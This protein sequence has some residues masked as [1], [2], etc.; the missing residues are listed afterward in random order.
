MKINNVILRT[1]ARVVV[2]II[3]TLAVYLFLAGHNNPGGGFI[4]G[5]V[6]STAFVLLFIVFDI[7]TIQKALP[8]DF[9]KVAAL[10][11]LLAVGT[12]F[13]SFLF[14]VSF[15]TQAFDYFD[16]PFF[17]E[18]ELTTVTIF[19]LGVA[20]VVVGVVV[21]IILSISEDV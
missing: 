12:G 5:L 20:L 8:F 10:G 11:A 13:G 18:V 9:K 6:L 17:G 21:T 14:D 16:L 1:V 7:E 19:E 3:L 4:G 15:L 2:Y